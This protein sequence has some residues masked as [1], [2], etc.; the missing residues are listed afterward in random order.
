MNPPALKLRRGKQ[1]E[2]D[3][4]MKIRTEGC[5]ENEGSVGRIFYRET[6]EIYEPWPRRGKW[7]W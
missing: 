5:E 7:R 4:R 3:D 6:R 1:D 2:Q